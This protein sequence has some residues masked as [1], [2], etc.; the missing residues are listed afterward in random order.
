MGE[1]QDIRR[2]ESTTY[3]GY[4]VVDFYTSVNSSV[5]IW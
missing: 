5:S 4:T 1:Y 2:P 3:R